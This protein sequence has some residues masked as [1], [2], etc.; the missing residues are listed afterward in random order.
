MSNIS[1]L[2]ARID[3]LKMSR[4]RDLE[5]ASEITGLPRVNS[6]PGPETSSLDEANSESGNISHP[7]SHSFNDEAKENSNERQVGKQNGFDNSSIPDSD[8]SEAT[9][10]DLGDNFVDLGKSEPKA[11][12]IREELLSN[13]ILIGEKSIVLNE[14][15]MQAVSFAYQ[16]ISFCLIGAAGTGKT[17]AVRK[18]TQTLVDSGTIPKLGTSTKSLNVGMLGIV[19]VAF[20]RK[21]ANNIRRAVIPELRSNVMTIHKLLEFQPEYEEV[22][23]KEHPGMYK[24]IMMFRPAR[25]ADNP[26]PREIICVIH[27]ETS[28]EGVEL[29]NLLRAAMPHTHQEIFLGDI[30]QLPPVFGRAVLGFKMLELPVIELIEVHR[31][32][33][34]SPILDLAWKILEGDPYDFSGRFDKDPVTKRITVPAL[35]KLSRENEYGSVKFEYWQQSLAVDIALKAVM[36][37]MKGWIADG[38]YNPEEDIILCPYNVQFG[39]VEINKLI[40]DYLGRERGAVVHEIIAGF[41]KYY[42]AVGDRVLHDKEDAFIVAIEPN[43]AYL[44]RD[45]QTPSVHLDRWGTQQAALSELEMSISAQD[46]EAAALAAME[47]YFDATV[48][49]EI[50]DRVHSCSHIMTCRY[51][52]DPQGLQPFKISK[53]GDF[54]GGKFLG[55]YCITVHKF[56]G[57]ETDKVFIFLHSSHAKASQRELLYTAVTRA[58]KHLYILCETNTFEKG[59]KSQKI[60]GNTLAEKAIIFEG[61]ARKGH[62]NEDLVPRK[63]YDREVIQIEERTSIRREDVL[64]GQGEQSGLSGDSSDIHGIDR[65]NID[66]RV[67][68]TL[69]SGSDATVA[70]PVAMPT[71]TKEDKLTALRM[72]L[73]GR[74]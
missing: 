6:D 59:I 69:V 18:I 7:Y 22:P 27:E 57:S 26:L 5:L 50:E 58:R 42:Y 47:T 38:Y 67:S 64:S 23:D 45:Y 54:N 61:L 73:L 40:M 9:G 49:D 31:Q 70:G 21:A 41:D 65:E 33:R 53:A 25:N 55:G 43:P 74:R 10:S 46:S 60:V 36:F 34:D 1:D 29:Y 19:I 3:A 62:E 44:K 37:R 39:T 56:Q 8:S 4:A 28:M 72:K 35:D 48:V 68:P 71:M 11:F 32:A 63:S 17:T 16:G 12:S 15:Q 51:A 2:R 24:N 30:Q 13:T 20:T 52:D 14:R 66:S